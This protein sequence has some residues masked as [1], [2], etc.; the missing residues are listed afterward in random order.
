MTLGVLVLLQRVQLV[1]VND[2]LRR[3]RVSVR[4]ALLVFAL[5]HGGRGE[6]WLAGKRD[7]ENWETLCV[8]QA[9]TGTR[10][11]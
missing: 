10:L 9:M 8:E 3:G 5:A 4:S 2:M 7:D 6:T 1:C 11:C